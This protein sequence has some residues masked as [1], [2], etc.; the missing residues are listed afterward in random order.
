MKMVGGM[1]LGLVVGGILSVS[2]GFGLRYVGTI[3]GP[4]LSAV[5]G[6]LVGGAF[7]GGSGRG[8]RGTITGILLGAIG[9][10]VA[11]SAATG[12]GFRGVGE[13]EVS[14]D[15]PR[16]LVLGMITGGLVGGVM[17]AVPEERP[18]D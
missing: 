18:K 2:I 8:V 14:L 6:A 10:A 11:G 15:L 3:Q 13:R 1:A 7:G 9:G 17:G 4:Q 12:V 16:A 5:V